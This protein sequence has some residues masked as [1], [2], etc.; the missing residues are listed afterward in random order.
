MTSNASDDSFDLSDLRKHNAQAVARLERLAGGH[1]AREERIE[2]P[3]N[4]EVSFLDTTVVRDAPVPSSSPSKHAKSGSK[5]ATLDTELVKPASST[6]GP[7]DM[8]KWKP[9]NQPGHQQDVT[10][11]D[12]DNLAPPADG[13]RKEDTTK[14]IDV[15]VTANAGSPPQ[16]VE[17]GNADQLSP[18]QGPSFSVSRRPS[19]LQIRSKPPSPQPWDLVDPP[20]DNMKGRTLPESVAYQLPATGSGKFMDAQLTATGRRLIPKSSYYSGPPPSDAAY[21]TPPMGHIGVHHP[22]EVLRVERDFTGGEVIQ[23]A[24]IYPLELEGRLTPTQ[25]LESI[26]SINEVLISAHSLRHAFLDN[27]ITLMSLQL[28]RLVMSTHFQKE[29][30]KLRSLVGELNEISFNPVGLNILWPGDV[31]FQFLEIEYY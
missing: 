3:R 29:L 25:F 19:A 20:D 22:R 8:T 9:S 4:A 14:V 30:K 7:W 10:L 6:D 23:F 5:D 31:A 26:N 1:K 2:E 13:Q 12:Q 17:H 16:E 28:S 24:P 18:V 21:G 27:V 15:S 11:V